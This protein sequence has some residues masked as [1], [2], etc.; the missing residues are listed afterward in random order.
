MDTL[1]NTLKLTSHLRLLYVEDNDDARESTLEVLGEFFQTIVIAKDGA[2]G[3]HKFQT[4]EIDLIVTDINMPNMDGI[5]MIKEIRKVDK[6]IPILLLSAYS[7]VEYFIES[8]RFG[9]DGYLFKPLELKQ[10]LE[11]LEKIVEKVSLQSK[12]REN[13]NFLKQYQDITDESAIVSKV[14]LQGFITHANEKLCE[15]SEYSLDELLG[16]SQNML[17]HPDNDARAF[18]EIWQ[19][20]YAEKKS[21]K[22]VVRNISKS[23]KSYYAEMVVRPI[24]NA[25]DEIL[26]FIII[27]HDITTIM[28]PKKQ[29]QDFMSSAKRV[30]IFEVKIEYYLDIEQYYSEK[31]A[32]KI[33]EELYAQML[34]HLPAELDFH[35]FVLGSGTYVFVK[36][37]PDE[38]E[39]ETLIHQIRVFQRKINDLVLHVEEVSYDI[40]ILVSLAYDEAAYENVKYGM[41]AL[42]KNQKN[43]IVANGMSLSAHKEVEENFEMLKKIKYAIDN[44]DILSFFQPIVNA[45]GVIEKYESLVRLRDVDQNIMAPIFFLDVAKRA[46][47]YTQITSIVLK[48]SFAG[49]GKTDKAISINLS[50]IDIEKH[51]I[52]QEIYHLLDFHKEDAHRIV[53]EFLED[54][55]F[56]DFTV[57]KDFIAEVKSY[58]VK[59]AIDDFGAGYSNFVRLLDYQPDIIKIDGSIVKNIETSLFSLS[60]VKSVLLF[61]KDQKIQVVAEFVS[62]EQIF[63]MLHELGVDYFQGFYFGKPDIL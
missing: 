41:A 58:G 42:L 9:V 35:S 28:S 5:S 6:E 43:F 52:R 20:I 55:D 34:E 45:E 48:N 54:E 16:A 13:L 37:S 4:Q 44:D 19:Q 57:L 36:D 10:F 27:C 2:Q 62:N 33:E 32:Q 40:S 18:N 14:N 51:Q 56:K 8:I 61:A 50:A 26:E 21:H 46:K 49:L 7:E 3:L 59:I 29:L 30:F 31:L 12:L 39:Y 15:V 25:E 22:S 1:K 53:F 17:R 24:L 38:N 23:G 11:S 60:V 47:Y 63:N